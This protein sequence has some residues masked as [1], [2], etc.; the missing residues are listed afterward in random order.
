MELRSF[1]WKGGFTYRADLTRPIEASW[2]VRKGTDASGKLDLARHKAR[3]K[4]ESQPTEAIYTVSERAG[5]LSKPPMNL[6]YSL[7]DEH[8][9]NSTACFFA[10]VKD[11]IARRLPKTRA[12]NGV[13]GDDRNLDHALLRLYCFF[14]S[15]IN[16]VIISSR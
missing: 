11:F 1:G 3:C 16:S 13:G 6:V 10:N 14:S 12:V 2:A 15:G 4:Q 9:D 5:L 7:R 8:H